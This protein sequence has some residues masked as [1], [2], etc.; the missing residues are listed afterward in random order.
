MPLKK[1]NP[2]KLKNRNKPW[3][4]NEILHKINYKN[5]VFKNYSECK[6]TQINLKNTLYAEYKE[7]NIT[8]Q[9]DNIT[10]SHFKKKLL[11]QLLHQ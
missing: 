8:H 10:H 2:K 11:Y 9:R 7:L 1:V 4:T 5:K 3:V 6:T